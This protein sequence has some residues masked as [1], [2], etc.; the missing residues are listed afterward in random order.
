[1]ITVISPLTLVLCA[2]IISCVLAIATPIF[3]IVLAVKAETPAPLIGGVGSIFVFA[4]IAITL[5]ENF[6]LNLL[7]F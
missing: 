5:G 1:M 7:L 2:T 3:A 4:N 6:H